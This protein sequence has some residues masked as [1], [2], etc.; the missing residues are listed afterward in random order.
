LKDSGSPVKLFKVD[1]TVETDLASHF[2]IQSYPTLIWIQ[3]EKVHEFSGGRVEREIVQWVNKRSLSPSR[4]FDDSSEIEQEL[5]KGNVVV[6]FWGDEFEPLYNL[7]IQAARPYWDIV[8]LH[9]DSKKIKTDNGV[10]E[11]IRFSLFREFESR[12]LD[13]SNEISVEHLKTFI[14]ENSVPTLMTLSD[15]YLKMIYG[16][17]NDAILLLYSAGDDNER[18]MKAISDAASQLKGKIYFATTDTNSEIG[19]KIATYFGL[20]REEIPAIVLSHF[21]KK[22]ESVKYIMQDRINKDNIVKFFESFKSGTLKKTPRSDKI[23][24]RNDGHLKT[25]VGKTFKDIVLDENKDALIYFYVP[26]CKECKEWI[27][28]WETFSEGLYPH[29]NLLFGKMDIASNDYDFPPLNASVHS[30]FLFP[31]N[32]KDKPVKYLGESTEEALLSFLKSQNVVNQVK[33]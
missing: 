23:P 29:R 33:K 20:E 12:R 22:G 21:P 3:E 9:T 10:K 17:Y 14:E 7:F 18:A 15:R 2:N 8:F 6:V 31:K 19:Q 24:E 32:S 28:M 25:I 1:A 4:P 30:L 26:Q 16:D 5:Q 11:N 13:F 27:K